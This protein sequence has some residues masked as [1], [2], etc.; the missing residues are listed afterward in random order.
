[1]PAET[2]L[3]ELPGLRT[4]LVHVVSAATGG[5]VQEGCLVGLRAVLEYVTGK[6]VADLGAPDARY[7]DVLT[8]VVNQS[9]WWN[10]VGAAVVRESASLSVCE[11]ARLSPSARVACLPVCRSLQET[12]TSDAGSAEF[13]QL[14]DSVH[15]VFARAC[16]AAGFLRIPDGRTLEVPTERGQ[17][18]AA[19]LRVAIGNRAIAV[20]RTAWGK[21]QFAWNAF[22]VV[23]LVAAFLEMVRMPFGPRF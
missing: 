10:A 21:W 15:G 13:R 11:G 19:E 16:S 1:V 7:E 3:T 14:T 23:V 5:R 18:I 20:R 17:R 12:I 6:S 2:A 22:K 8:V 4:A 9:P